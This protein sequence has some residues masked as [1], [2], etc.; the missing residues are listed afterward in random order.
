MKK[1]GLKKYIIP[2]EESEAE[3]Y[4]TKEIRA[5]KKGLATLQ[6]TKEGERLG[7]VAPKS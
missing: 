3:I 4:Q 2:E 5:S 7:E 6:M 1:Y